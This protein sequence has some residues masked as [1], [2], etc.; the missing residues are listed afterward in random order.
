M[1]NITILDQSFFDSKKKSILQK[2]VFG[3]TT[4]HLSEKKNS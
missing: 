2:K 4:F 3:Y 1:Q